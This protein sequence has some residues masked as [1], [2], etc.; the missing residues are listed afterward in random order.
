MHGTSALIP[1]PLLVEPIVGLRVGDERAARRVEVGVI[2]GARVL[3]PQLVP[4]EGDAP[5]A[6]PRLGAPDR[7]LAADTPQLAHLVRRRRPPPPAPRQPRR[8][9][10]LVARVRERRALVPLVDPRHHHPAAHDARE[11]AVGARHRVGIELEREAAH[12]LRLHLLVL[13]A[14]HH[15]ERVDAELGDHERPAR[16]RLVPARGGGGGGRRGG[17]RGRRCGR[18][19]ARAAAAARLEKTAPKEAPR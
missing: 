7:G 13:G 8:A 17:R 16:H 18:A 15:V 12:P 3:E 6:V 19:A 2:V 1:Q 5:R 10:A 4:P 14:R 11:A 9:A